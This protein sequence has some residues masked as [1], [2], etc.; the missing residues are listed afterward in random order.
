LKYA[1]NYGKIAIGKSE[2]CEGSGNYLTIKIDE[3]ENNLK[4]TPIIVIFH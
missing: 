1:S 3:I 4:L 2:Q